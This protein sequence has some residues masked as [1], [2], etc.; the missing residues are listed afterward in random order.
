MQTGAQTI[1]CAQNSRWDPHHDGALLVPHWVLARL[2]GGG[3][4]LGSDSA[5]PL[6]PC[7]GQVP[8]ILF[9]VGVLRAKTVADVSGGIQRHVPAGECRI[10]LAHRWSSLLVSMKLESCFFHTLLKTFSME[11]CKQQCTSQPGDAAEKCLHPEPKKIQP[12]SEKQI[13]NRVWQLQPSLLGSGANKAC[14]T[15]LGR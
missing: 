5:C 11:L 12:A 7:T 14:T 4:V 9:L 6:A 8:R 1:T 15:I 10:A 2:G 3:P 13:R